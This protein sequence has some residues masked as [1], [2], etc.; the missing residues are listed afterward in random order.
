MEKFVMHP[1]LIITARPDEGFRRG[2]LHHPPHPVEHPPGTLSDAELAAIR[3]EPR[4]VVVEIPPPQDGAVEAQADP[5]ANKD[6][7]VKKAKGEG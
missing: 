2:G 7:P 4:L 3:A 5:A 6:A 1:T